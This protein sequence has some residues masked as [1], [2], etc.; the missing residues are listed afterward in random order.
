MKSKVYCKSTDKGTHSFYL[1]HNSEEIWLFNQNYRKSVQDYFG[2]GRTIDESIKA[3]K[4]RSRDGARKDR[5]LRRTATKIPLYLKYI[6]KE[7]EIQVM[8]KTKRR[9][10]K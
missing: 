5:A 6:E 3:Y 10:K 4:V 8:E 9:R 1:V 7:Y 2:R